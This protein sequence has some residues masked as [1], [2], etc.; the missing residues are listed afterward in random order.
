MIETLSSPIHTRPHLLVLGLLGHRFFS[1]G[2]LGGP[3]QKMASTFGGGP[4]KMNAFVGDRQFGT[5][6]IH[7]NVHLHNPQVF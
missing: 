1:D 4:V 7:K 6:S 3:P 2:F 5:V